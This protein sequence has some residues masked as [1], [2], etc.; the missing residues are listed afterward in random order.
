VS[1]RA[2]E[3][4]ERVL[5]RGGEPDDVLRAA[6]EA[7]AAEP[8]VTWA[9]IAL[10]EEGQLVVGPQAGQEDDTRRTQVP[11]VFQGTAIGE[12]WVDGD[13]DPAQLAKVAALVSGH[14]LIGWDTGGE[15]WEP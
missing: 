3:A 5:D 9:G 4:I 1:D 8:E 7:L 11:V 10:L 2:I 6:V 12:L 13:V 15:P 14:V